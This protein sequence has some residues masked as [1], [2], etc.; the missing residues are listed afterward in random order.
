MEDLLQP[1]QKEP[2]PLG[3][4]QN[5]HGHLTGDCK[6]LRAKI[7]QLLKA[8]HLKEFLSDRPKQNISKNRNGEEPRKPR[9]PK[10]TI[11][12]IIG[13]EAV[14]G[15]TYSASKKTKVSLSSSKRDR[16]YSQHD[17]IIFSS[18]DYIWLLYPHNDAL[19]ISLHILN[20]KIKYVLID[21]GSPA[22]IIL[23]RVLEEMQLVDKIFQS[24]SCWLGS[25]WPAR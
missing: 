3:Y 13:R 15:V 10:Q 12:M 19:V 11:H 8:E 4:F 6:N 17:S 24:Q 14:S 21:P 2:G 23:L 7:A 20:S 16:D 22:N 5:T 25:T 9:P 1:R 18:D